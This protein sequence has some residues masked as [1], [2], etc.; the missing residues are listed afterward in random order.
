MKKE[1]HRSIRNV[2]FL[3]A[4]IFVHAAVLLFFMFSR[5]IFPSTE[6][7]STKTEPSVQF[8]DISDIPDL[9]KQSLVEQDENEKATQLKPKDPK[10]M[11][12]VDKAVEKETRAVTRGDFKNENSKAEKPTAKQELNEKPAEKVA[13]SE[14]PAAEAKEMKT[15]ANGDFDLGKKKTIG[16]AKTLQDLKSTSFEDVSRQAFASVSQTNDHIKDVV[17]GAETQ[18]NTR[19]FLYYTYFNRI[20]KKLRQHWE[21]IIHEKVRGLVR[22][23]RELASNSSST[24]RLIITL[25]AHGGLSRVQVV[26]TSGVQDLDEAA[27]EALKVAAPFPNPPKDLI[28]DGI[29]Q[30]N[31]DFVLES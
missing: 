8:I 11:S 20:K 26:T 10:Y 29:V 25:D 1:Q 15:F 17:A 21:P 28:T 30:I 22:K 9:P 2:S 23:G 3:V 4:S 19:E 24:T 6:I 7:A 18:L 27:I 13:K 31:W 5:S 14:P 12:K 16:K